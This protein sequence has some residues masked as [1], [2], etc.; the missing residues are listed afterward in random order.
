MNILRARKINYPVWRLRAIGGGRF[1]AMTESMIR[2][3]RQLNLRLSALLVSLLLLLGASRETFSSSLAASSAPDNPGAKQVLTAYHLAG[4]FFGR[5]TAPATD[6]E[7]SKARDHLLFEQ[8]CTLCHSVDLVK[9]ST[10]GWSRSRTR[11]ALDQ[12]NRLHPAMPD[13]LGT[14]QEKDRLA[15]YIY[16]LNKE[17]PAPAPEP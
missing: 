7:P 11:T 2:E 9:E 14:P 3:K 15:D 12:L 17:K 1:L 8:N 16:R 6:N 10:V 13:Y 4:G 5:R